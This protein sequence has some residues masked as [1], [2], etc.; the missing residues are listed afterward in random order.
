MSERGPAKTTAKSGQT[1][2]LTIT[3]ASNSILNGSLSPVTLLETYLKRIEAVD[4]QI[5]S[6]IHVDALGARKAA[7]T[8]ADEIAAGNWRGPLHGLPFAVKDN[9]DA[10]GLP[11]TAN[12]KLRID[13]VPDCDAELVRRLKAAGAVLIGKLATWEYGTGNG[14]EYYDLPFPTARNPWNTERFPGGS[15]TGAGVSV[16]AGTT[17]FALG[18]DTTGSVRLPAAATGTVG[19]IPTPGRLSLDGILPNCYSLDNPGPFTWTVEDSAIVLEAIADRTTW[20]PRGEFGFRRALRQPVAGMRVA[21]VTDTGPGMADPDPELADGLDQAVRDLETLG[22]EVTVVKL[23]VAPSLCFHVTSILGPAE[24]AAIHE[25][26]LRERPEDMG[27][28]LRDKLMFGS[29]LRA[30]D[31]I[32]AQRQR[33]TIANAIEE[34]IRGFDALVTFGTLHLPPRLGVEPEMTAF[35]KDTMLT[36]FNLS[37]HPAMIQ[38]TGFTETGLPLN[39][40]IVANRGDEASIYRLA[41]AYETA[42]PWRQRRPQL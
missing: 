38:C 3:E 35:T 42:T 27:Y 10:E 13:N 41:S 7:K 14:G 40:Q 1:E 31:Y 4:E 11:A 15:S 36:P 25:E 29:M 39:W 20:D 17:M 16:A 18:S 30:V 2:P 19:I 21:V 6:F 22:V 26:E 28:A 34:L 24:S 23:P 8:A 9:Y 32:A 12:S 37:A 5:H 33:L